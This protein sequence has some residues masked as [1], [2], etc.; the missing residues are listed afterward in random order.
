MFWFRCFS[1]ALLE[2]R[3]A[4]IYAR[5]ARRV[6]ALDAADAAQAA[7]WVSTTKNQRLSACFDAFI[8]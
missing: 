7:V 4:S 2:K 6:G 8:T 3:V 1:K 5:Q